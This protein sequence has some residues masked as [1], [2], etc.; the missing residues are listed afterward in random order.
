MI[1]NLDINNIDAD[2]SFLE[3]KNIFSPFRDS[4]L[5]LYEDN[6]N[7]DKIVVLL[8]YW[9][10]NIYCLKKCYGAKGVIDF[11]D[12]VSTNPQRF[13]FLYISFGNLIFP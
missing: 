10:L 3:H 7:K 9:I 8:D 6:P 12:S 4:F 5:D 1:T 11:C 13:S 2:E